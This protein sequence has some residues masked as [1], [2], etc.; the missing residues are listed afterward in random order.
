MASTGSIS[1]AKSRQNGKHSLTFFS[2][3]PHCHESLRCH[4]MTIMKRLIPQN[5]IIKYFHNTNHE[6]EK[7]SGV[8]DSKYSFKTD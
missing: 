3:Y 5:T 2:S 7:G 8:V 6:A 1:P 4:T